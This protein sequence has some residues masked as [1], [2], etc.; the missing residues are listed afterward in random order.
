MY[1]INSTVTVATILGPLE[2][3]RIGSGDPV[4]LWHSLF[5]DSGTF[6]P[7]TGV[8][9]KGRSLL[10]I[11]GPGHGESPGPRKLYT[12]SDCA[13]AASEILDAL[14]LPG[15]VDW[16]GNA[17]GGHVG[18]LFAGRFPG[19]C[20][21]LVTISTPAYPLAGAER[22]RSTALVYLYR[23]FGPGPFRSL[24]S[25]ALVG[26][27]S[28][29]SAPQAVR[30]VQEAFCGGDRQGKYW[31]MQSVMLHRGNLRPFLRE[32]PTPTIMIVGRDDPMNDSGV[33]RATAASMPDGQF[34]EAPGA[35]HVAPL[36]C[37]PELLAS[38]ISSFWRETHSRRAAP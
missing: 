33:A 21:S 1:P 2:V 35:G 36:L 37:S 22:V 3:H 26:R 16:V 32:L 12:L 20:R 9:P 5:V 14:E 10:L 28:A 25:D 4:V 17:W 23:L 27:G 34:A 24:V 7:L 15:P 8:L 31:A 6:G 13:T 19:R 29:T 38:L 18:V 11:D 30:N